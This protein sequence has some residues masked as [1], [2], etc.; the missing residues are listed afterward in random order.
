MRNSSLHKDNTDAKQGYRLL[1]LL[2]LAFFL[3]WAGMFF[4]ETRPYT[5]VINGHEVQLKGKHSA[6]SLIADG[7]VKSRPGNLLAIDGS[8][9][10][11]G[12]GE[13]FAVSFE[14]LDEVG[15]DTR[16]TAGDT[17]YIGKGN[18][19][20]EPIIENTE[21]IQPGIVMEGTGPIHVVEP[22]TEG[23]MLIKTGV[24]SGIQ[25][26]EEITPPVPDVCRKYYPD[27]GGEKVI[28]LTLDDGPW[29]DSTEDILDILAAHQV[30]ATFFFVG[31]QIESSERN[32][33]LV[34]RAFNEGHQVATHTYSHA[35][36][37]GLGLSLE[38]MDPADQIEE[39][40]KGFESIKY[41]TGVDP[42]PILRAPGG[43]YSPETQQILK[44]YITAEIGWTVD[45]H[46]WAFP[47]P[48]AIVDN[49]MSNSFSGGIILA[50]D[51]GGDRRGTVI[52]LGI[53]IPQ[54][55]EQG[56]RFVTI[57]ELLEYPP[58]ER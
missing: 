24:Q 39:V 7:T 6:A 18:D 33:S 34:K 23:L 29:G 10:V 5:V 48:E 26:T 35:S 31:T 19:V 42:S 25:L 55:K 20:V 43:N 51:G 41:V 3:V 44:P 16:L 8:I 49:I 12:G 2:V 52:A 36:G 4:A 17:L 50:H 22:G 37:D 1:A 54:L 40:V 45:T 56:Y 58:L 21:L 32:A 46:D 13:P 27:T 15:P 28:A 30:K 47:P 11:E 9:I 14:G 57:D 53:A 38:Y